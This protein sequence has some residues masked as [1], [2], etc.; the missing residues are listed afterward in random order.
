VVTQQ[1]ICADSE[2]AQ[3]PSPIRISSTDIRAC[4][5]QGK[6]D[7]AK[8]LLGHPLCLS[9]RVIRGDQRGRELGFPTA[10]IRLNH[11]MAYSGVFAVQ[12]RVNDHLLKG[13]AN[14]GS[15]PT[16]DNSQGKA[17]FLEIYF[18]DFRGDLYGQRLHVE[19]LQKI[20]EEVRF[21]SLEA[22]KAQIAQDVQAAKTILKDF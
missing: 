12:A 5:N 15:R 11:K 17:R 13:V 6:F 1:A 20:R 3:G 14:I 7:E 2:S 22:L 19:L 10:N 18:F 8:A 21:D 16:V 9:G 4:I